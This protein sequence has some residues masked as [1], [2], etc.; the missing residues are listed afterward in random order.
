MSTKSTRGFTLVE[1]IVVI[2]ILVILGTIAFLNMGSFSASARD[3]Q[4]TSDLNQ[5]NSQIMTIQAKQGLAYSSMVSSGSNNQLT[6][7]S[8]AGVA[9]VVGTDYF[10]G[11]VNYTALGID[12]TKFKDPT[13]AVAY[14]MGTTTLAGTAY[15]LAASLEETKQALVMG[16]FRS[17]TNIAP[18]MSVGSGTVSASALSVVTITTADIGKFKINDTLAT[19]AGAVC[20]TPKITGISADL[21]NLTLS[22]TCTAGTIAPGGLKLAADETDGLIAKY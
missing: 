13:K 15:E 16:T 9:S 2:T 6:T 12:G 3:S 19:T 21:L 4:R 14:K 7:P 10:A 1:L 5:I 20:T 17:R 11:D 18:D 22:V 8:I